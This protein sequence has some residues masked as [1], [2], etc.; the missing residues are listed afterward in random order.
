MGVYKKMISRGVILCTQKAT[1]CFVSA[2][3]NAEIKRR[4]YEEGLFRGDSFGWLSLS[5]LYG[6]GK[7]ASTIHRM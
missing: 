7:I 6:F 1:C 3:S 5:D 2:P 4:T